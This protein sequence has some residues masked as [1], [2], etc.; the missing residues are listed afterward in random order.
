[1][2]KLLRFLIIEPCLVSQGEV[3]N[4]ITGWSRILSL[5]YECTQW[6]QFVAL[7]YFIRVRD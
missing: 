3:W 6:V 1:M 4:R 2:E 7:K 5:N